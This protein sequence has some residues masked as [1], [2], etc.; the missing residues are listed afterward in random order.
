MILCESL[1]V[2]RSATYAVFINNGPREVGTRTDVSIIDH[3]VDVEGFTFVDN[4]VHRQDDV[5]CIGVVKNGDGSR[6]R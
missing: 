3:R 1:T 2:C 4:G 6:H 5:R